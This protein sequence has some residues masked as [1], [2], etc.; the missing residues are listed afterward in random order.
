ME[1]NIE[2]TIVMPSYNRG[3]FLEEAI[4]SVLQ[5]EVSFQYKL[6]IVD[7]GS[8]DNSINIANFYRDKHPGKIEVMPSERNQ[9]LLPN[10]IRAYQIMKTKYFCVLDADDY[11]IDKKFLQNAYVFLENNQEY[12]IYGCNS[13]IMQDGA[14]L[15]KYYHV[16]CKDDMVINSID[17]IME[18]GKWRYVTNTLETVFRNVIFEKG[19]PDF[20]MKSVG[21]YSEDSYREDTNRYLMHLRKGK[22]KYTNNIVGVYRFHNKGIWSL[23]TAFH[24]EVYCARALLDYS[25]YYDKHYYDDF[26]KLSNEYFI[27][28]TA[29]LFCHI[30]N[31]KML[32]I[33]DLSNYGDLLHNY[34]FTKTDEQKYDTKLLELVQNRQKRELIV[35]GTGSAAMRLVD[36]YIMLENVSCFVDSNPEKQGNSIQGKQIISPSQIKDC[37]KDKYI[38]IASTYYNEIIIDILRQGLCDEEEIINLYKMD[39]KYSLIFEEMYGY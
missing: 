20:M 2:M 18:G 26:C 3:E 31:R 11:W 9:G 15:D 39:Y 4:Q 10:C 23:K 7:D 32:D 1:Q 13:R 24:K 36:K 37:R 28:A 30:W 25:V 35:W 22:A 17:D 33:K 19:V 12:T 5:Q 21:T 29:N 38:V 14:L 34:A 8:N 27:K 16:N 6:I